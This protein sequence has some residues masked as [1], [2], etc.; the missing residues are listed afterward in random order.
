MSVFASS[1]ARMNSDA[2]DEPRSRVNIKSNKIIPGKDLP[3]LDAETK[4]LITGMGRDPVLLESFGRQVNGTW[5]LVISISDK[6][7]FTASRYESGSVRRV[8]DV[9]NLACSETVPVLWG[10]SE[11]KY[12]YDME[13]D[14]VRSQVSLSGGQIRQSTAPWQKKKQDRQT[15]Q[16]VYCDDAMLVSREMSADTI[17]DPDLYSVWKRVLPTVW[18]KY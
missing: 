3:G 5:D 10:L 7:P 12:W 17:S 6:A 2:Y 18:R 8:L 13:W 16:V 11:A 1:L 14:A 4:A 9:V 15:F